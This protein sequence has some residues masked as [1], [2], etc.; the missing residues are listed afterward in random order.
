MNPPLAPPVPLCPPAPRSQPGVTLPV[1]EAGGTPGTRPGC[2]C[3][4]RR[5][6]GQRWHHRAWLGTWPRAL[7]HRA[8]PVGCPQG[9]PRPRPHRVLPAAAA[10]A[11]PAGPAVAGG[12]GRWPCTELVLFTP[13]RTRDNQPVL[14]P[15]CV[16]AGMRR[17]AALTGAP[18]DP[19]VGSVVPAVAAVPSG[20]LAAA[21]TR[22]GL[23]RFAAH[24]GGR[25]GVGAWK[26]RDEGAVRLE[27]RAAI[28][29]AAQPGY[30]QQG[31]NGSV[32]AAPPELRALQQEG[33]APSKLHTELR[34]CPRT[35][36]SRGETMPEVS[37]TCSSAPIKP[38]MASQLHTPGMGRGVSQFPS[39]DHLPFI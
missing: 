11:D 28:P 17:S 19:A 32:T 2:C 16:L 34:K 14:C 20:V 35:R 3:C 12:G 6:W 10:G 29:G 4:G 15:P 1:R 21:R 22:P 26:E 25:C 9:A 13:A 8:K 39:A 33:S 36:E 7:C 24:P 18:A 38:L 23:G 31:Y 5:C 30:Q 27:K 37:I